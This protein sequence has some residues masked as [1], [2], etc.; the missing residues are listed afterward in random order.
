VAGSCEH[1][2]ERLGSIKGRTF[3]DQLSNFQL[4]RCAL[5]HGVSNFISYHE[6]H[7]FMIL[8]S[9][10]LCV[11]YTSADFILYCMCNIFC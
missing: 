5:V 9:L 8:L 1:M 7:F 6:I 11:M 4:V 2:N 3:C 10:F